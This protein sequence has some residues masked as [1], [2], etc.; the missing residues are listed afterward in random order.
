SIARRG[1]VAARVQ[2]V[3]MKIGSR[4]RILARLEL[5]LGQVQKHFWM[6]PQEVGAS[7]AF[8]R[9]GVVAVLIRN[10]AFLESALGFG[11]IQIDHRSGLAR[12][13]RSG[14][15]VLGLRLATRQ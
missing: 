2:H 3:R 13:R 7:E 8:S 1:I 11:R 15:S 14:R 6:W 5:A 10:D 4:L 12:R 9:F